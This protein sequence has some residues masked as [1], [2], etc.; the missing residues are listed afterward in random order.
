MKNLILAIIFFC[1]GYFFKAPIWQV[2]KAVKQK[3]IEVQEPIVSKKNILLKKYIEPK[4][5]V[6]QGEDSKEASLASPVIK[7]IKTSGDRSPQ[8]EKVVEKGTSSEL[9]LNTQ[10]SFESLLDRQLQMVEDLSK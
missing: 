6:E 10:E 7:G 8:I 1:V 4:T 9:I 2:E 5:A 3:V